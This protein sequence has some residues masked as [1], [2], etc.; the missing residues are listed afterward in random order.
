LLSAGQQSAT[1]TY[2]AEGQAAHAL[3]EMCFIQDDDPYSYIGDEFQSEL[4]PIEVDEEMADAAFVYLE[5]CREIGKAAK[6]CEVEKQVDVNDLWA[7]GSQPADMFGTSDFAAWGTKDRRLSI[8]DFKYGKGVAV[9]VE[10][11]GKLNPQLLYY[12]L[13]VLLSIKDGDARPLWV[14]VYVCQPR[15]DHPLGPIRKA[16]I[17]TLDLLAW[18]HETLKPGAEACFSGNPKAVVGDGCRWCPARGRCP[19]LRQVA[20]ETARVEF[21]ALPPQ[22][23]DLSDAEL[24]AILDKTEIIRAFIDGV[25]GEASS[26]IDRGGKVPGWKLVQKRG[27]R[28][29]D[30]EKLVLGKLEDM[31]LPE[32]KAVSVK[33]K[34]PAQIEKLLKDKEA[35]ETLTD[36]ISKDSS[37]TT[38][39]R[40]LDPRQAAAA[41][42]A[43]DFDPVD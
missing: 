16:S 38:L 3:T 34:S 36:H 4:G 7:D 31:G 19:A 12:A 8:V 20:Q 27:I 2:A 28:K 41:G 39:V 43:S 22:P 30:N 18:G 11:L 25:R 21:D 10:K 35:F 33:L 1:S 40:E 29:W 15:A 17:S 13:G 9:D 14:D 42:P 32:D 26:R 24:G 23:V 5:L 37:G 6:F